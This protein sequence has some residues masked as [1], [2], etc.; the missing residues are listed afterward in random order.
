[1][2]GLG[3]LEAE[4]GFRGQPQGQSDHFTD[5]MSHL[6]LRPCGADAEQRVKGSGNTVTAGKEPQ[7]E[8]GRSYGQG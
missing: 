1:M 5:I 8:I 6:R 2:P 3:D 4:R 7:L